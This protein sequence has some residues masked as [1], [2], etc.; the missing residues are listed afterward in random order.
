MFF[1]VKN[2][3]MKVG[4]ILIIICNTITLATYHHRQ[5][6]Q[7]RDECDTLNIIFVTIFSIE[8]FSRLIAKDF[9]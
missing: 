1:M 8:I 4:W 3:R 2:K 6:P 9:S 5:Q 7:H